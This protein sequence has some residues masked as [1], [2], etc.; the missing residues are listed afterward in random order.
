MPV[1]V[2]LEFI[3]LIGSCCLKKCKPRHAVTLLL[4]SGPERDD[5]AGTCDSDEDPLAFKLP[6]Q[7]LHLLLAPA[8][9]LALCR[10]L[11]WQFE[12]LP[13][14]RGQ[15]SLRQ[16]DWGMSPS[17][18]WH[19][20]LSPVELATGLQVVVEVV[21]PTAEFAGVFSHHNAVA[22]VLVAGS[23]ATCFQFVL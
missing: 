7:P 6:P 3:R 11:R 13:I 10:V 14:H 2:R 22:C 21:R 4:L 19:S 5:E 15:R 8:R 9:A 20:P 17:E 16:L 18:L 12:H 23:V 1:L